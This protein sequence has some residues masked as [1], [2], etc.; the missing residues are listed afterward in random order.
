MI[1]G[2]TYYA[3]YTADL[4]FD[5]GSSLLEPRTY[6]YKRAKLV[7]M[8]NTCHTVSHSDSTDITIL[9]VSL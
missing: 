8:K 4:T 7:I 5:N 1:S 3:P 9:Q 6:T 2:G